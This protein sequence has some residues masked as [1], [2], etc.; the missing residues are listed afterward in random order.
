LYL[1][2]PAAGTV[3]VMLISSPED[4]KRRKLSRLRELPD[5]AECAE[6]PLESGNS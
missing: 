1:A 6:L 4:L 3:G 2:I 5:F